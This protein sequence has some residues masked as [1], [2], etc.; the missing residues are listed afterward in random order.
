MC[1]AQDFDL[2]LQ[3]LA[4]FTPYVSNQYQEIDDKNSL[5]EPLATF[6]GENTFGNNEQ[7]VRHNAD[8]SMICAFLC[9]Y[10]KGKVT[11]PPS[12]S[13]DKLATMA[14]TTLTYSYSTHK[15]NRLYPCKNNQYWGSVSLDDHS[16][17]SS[18]W[19]MS[20]AY[21]AF[22]QWE[23]LS[24]KQ[25]EQ[26]YQLL[27]AECNYELER[28][29]PTGFKGDTKAEENGW[30]CD[31]LAA[32]LG[33]FPTDPLAEKWFKRL[34]SFAVNSYSH[35]MDEDNDEVVDPHYDQ[36]TIAQLYRGANLYDDFTLQNHNY[37]HTS[38]QNV[39]AQELGEAALALKLFQTDIHKQERWKT[40]TLMHQVG[41]VMDE[42]LYRLALADGELA[43]PNGND[44]SLFLYDQV[45]S[46]S[47]V[48][49]FLRDP[50][51]LMLEQRALRQIARRQKTTTDGSWLL[52]PDVGARRMGVQAHRVMMT[53]LMHHVLPTDDITPA[54]WQQFLTRYSETSY[55]PDQDV[56]TASSS[57]RFT[58]FSWSQGLKSYTGYFAPTSEEHNNIIVPF[59]TGNTG[60]FIGYYE[61]EGKKTDAVDIKHAIVYSDSNSYIISGTLETNERLLRNRYMLFATDH[62]LVLYF[63]MTRATRECTVKA[64]RGG[65]L[66]I[67][68][69]PFTRESR[70]I[71]PK[72][73]PLTS[74]ISNLKSDWVNIDNCVG[75]LT[76][77]FSPS[78]CIAFG[79]QQNN[80]SILTSKLYAFYS[81]TP[82]SLLAGDKVGTRLM[83][84][85][86]NV[87][88][89]QT[90]QLNQQM[91]PVTD[92]P[93][94]WEGYQVS[95][96]DG[97]LYLIIYNTTGKTDTR[98]NIE[99]ITNTYRPRLTIIATVVDGQFVVLPMAVNPTNKS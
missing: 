13:W 17:E 4:D 64:E 98:I 63:D 82:I 79:D 62:N 3:M 1:S 12:V 77:K 26:I 92:L 57:Q 31:V 72:I 75:I 93:T 38:Y 87:T 83:A 94:N 58:C 99:K 40:N 28:A 18:L 23:Q 42:V 90:Q 2:A 59:R 95:D 84:C 49:C 97:S 86:S 50:Y 44:W 43:M 76:R 25:R 46:F 41:F 36:T 14:R 7:G 68:T 74:Q 19:A 51:A 70:T 29:I 20:V 30:E 56:I 60:N 91:K 16:W 15:A 78:S 71:Y 69:D 11:L 9:K 45:T 37:F 39:V 54:T 35:P 33:L 88:A 73:S 53:W 22:F 48:S 96:T 34:R 27:K 32:T 24:A 67:S 61:V 47:T 85:Y 21:S 8:L 52:R 6:K 66:A 5:G 65:L 55:Y 81:D 10:A 89:E 80:N